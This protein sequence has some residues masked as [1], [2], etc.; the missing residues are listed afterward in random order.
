MKSYWHPDGR[1]GAAHTTG[2]PHPA[3][4]AQQ[5]C[6]GEGDSEPNVPLPPGRAAVSSADGTA[7]TGYCPSA[8]CRGGTGGNQ[9]IHVFFPSRTLPKSAKKRVHKIAPLMGTKPKSGTW[10]RPIRHRTPHHWQRRVRAGRLLR[11][12]QNAG[13]LGTGWFSV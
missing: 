12:A 7:A 2:P 4:D 8:A 1:A 3:A 13:L 10:P 6:A 5:S 9:P 11:H